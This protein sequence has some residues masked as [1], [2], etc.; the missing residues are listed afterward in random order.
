[1]DVFEAI[2]KRR[3]VRSYEPTPVPREKL[4]RILEAAR[5]APS[6]MNLQP[7]HFIVVTDAGKREK[8]AQA[9]YAGF[10]REA[11]VVIVGCGNEKLS[12]K[13]FIID[14]TIAMQNMVIMATSEGLGTCWIGS[15]NEKE[16]KELLRIP[17]EFRVVALLALGYPADKIDIQR[18]LLHLV[19]RRKKLEDITSYEEFGVRQRL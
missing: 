10:L 16:V 6:A 2:Q 5:L 14:V 9:P 1:M 17:E 15:F 7:W 19:R 3:S 8:L 4:E 12:P 11:P 18:G 13:W